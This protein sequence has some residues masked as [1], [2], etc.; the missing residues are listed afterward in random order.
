MKKVF[1]VLAVLA[2]TFSFTSCETNETADEDQLFIEA[3]DGDEVEDP[4]D[5]GND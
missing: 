3:I 1:L 2:F 4:D 5:R